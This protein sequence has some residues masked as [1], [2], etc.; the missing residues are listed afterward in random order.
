LPPS[1]KKKLKWDEDHLTERG[2]GEPARIQRGSEY[3]KGFARRKSKREGS[4]LS[5]ICR[6]GVGAFST[7]ESSREKPG[8]AAESVWGKNN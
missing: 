7:L 5:R 3:E 1:K 8:P 4:L 6:R 2:K